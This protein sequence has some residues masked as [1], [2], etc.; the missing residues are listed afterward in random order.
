MYSAALCRGLIEAVS[1][2]VCACISVLGIPRL[3]AA[4]SLK[5]TGGRVDGPDVCRYSAALCR[6]LIEAFFAPAI[7][8]LSRLCIPRLYA[9]ASLKRGYIYRYVFLSPRGIPRLYAAA[10]LKLTHTSKVQRGRVCVFRG[11]MPRPH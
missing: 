3:Y 8:F 7:A 6:G 2:S 9:A 11:F 5:R 4:A 10:S 1:N